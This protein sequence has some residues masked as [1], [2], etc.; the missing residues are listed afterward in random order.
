MLAG[1]KY[2]L[3]SKEKED[4]EVP[5]IGK[6]ENKAVKTEATALTSHS[7]TVND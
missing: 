6:G 2:M 3:P 7:E 4:T 1:T 5:N